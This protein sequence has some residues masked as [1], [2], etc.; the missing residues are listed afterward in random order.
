MVSQYPATTTDISVYYW[1]PWAR[2][3]VLGPLSQHY[4]EELAQPTMARGKVWMLT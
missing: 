1:G 4:L 3:T 2:A